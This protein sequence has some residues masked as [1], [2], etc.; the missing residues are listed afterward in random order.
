ML[1]LAIIDEIQLVVLFIKPL[2]PSMTQFE[3]A[4]LSCEHELLAKLNPASSSISRIIFYLEFIHFGSKWSSPLAFCWVLVYAVVNLDSGSIPQFRGVFGD[5]VSLLFYSDYIPMPTYWTILFI[6]S[7]Q[8]FHLHLPFVIVLPSI[9]Q[10]LQ[11]SWIHPSVH[12]TS[13]NFS[14]WALNRGPDSEC[15]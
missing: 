3:F 11:I 1:F 4:I 2:A 14:A 13:P 15:F 9:I 5:F 12:P 6:L 10:K 7:S 8:P